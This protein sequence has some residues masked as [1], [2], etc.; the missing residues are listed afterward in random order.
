VLFLAS[1]AAS[2]MTG[3]ELFIGG[4]ITGGARPRWRATSVAREGSTKIDGA[5]PVSS[6]NATGQP[7]DEPRS[8]CALK[9]PS[10][11]LFVP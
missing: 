2:Y 1:D 3:V 5:T 6:A 4:G 7:K 11:G 10:N 8:V 9:S